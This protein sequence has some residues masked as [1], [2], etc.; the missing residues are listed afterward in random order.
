M[1]PDVS[2]CITG[3][4]AHHLGHIDQISSGEYN[5]KPEL[6]H[7]LE[8]TAIIDKFNYMSDKVKKREDT[9]KETNLKL[10]TEISDRREAEQA[11]RESE[12]RYRQLV[13]ELP[14]G[15]YRS[16]P[17]AEG[18]FL[19]ANPAIIEMFGYQSMDQLAGKSIKDLYQDPEMRRH[20]LDMLYSKIPAWT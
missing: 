13:E 6:F 18:P 2:A 5:E 16:S 19:M 7:H 3:M 11:L 8:I 20:I 1:P 14:V 15:I 17:E 12:K 4:T 9:L 10:G